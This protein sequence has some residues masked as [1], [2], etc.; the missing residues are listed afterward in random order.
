MSSF[1]AA[2]GLLHVARAQPSQQRGCPSPPLAQAVG[3]PETL[4]GLLASHNQREV[5]EIPF[6]YSA[7]YF[8]LLAW[9]NSL[10]LSAEGSTQFVAVPPPQ[11]PLNLKAGHLDGYC[12][13]E[14]WNS[15]AV[16]LRSGVI[17]ATSAEIA[18]MHPEKVLM[19]RREFA[20]SRSDGHKRFIAAPLE[21]CRC[22]DNAANRPQVVYGSAGAAITFKSNGRG[23]TRLLRRN[24][25]RSTA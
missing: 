6:L 23:F 8:L 1:V 18:P 20:G 13:G 5:L 9:L 15:M 19:I 4:R 16:L 7:R 2:D 21:A 12:A 25:G 3:I 10:G 14:P 11:V 24:N 17:A 22:C